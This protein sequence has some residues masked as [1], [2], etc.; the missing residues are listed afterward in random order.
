MRVFSDAEMQRRVRALQ[1]ELATL[2]ADAAVLHT[3]DNSFYVSG[4][5]LLSGWGRPAVTAVTAT[6]AATLVVAMIEKENG[7]RSSWITDVRAYADEENVHVVAARAIG[8][9]LRS[10]NAAR[11]RVG[12]EDEHLSLG[13]RRL[14]QEALPE[15]TFVSI[16]PAMSRLRI[17]KSEEELALLRLGGRIAQVGARAFLDVVREGATELEVTSHAVHEMNRALARERPNSATSTYAYCHS[18]VH[19]LTP[20]LHPTDRRLRSGEVVGLNV[21]PVIWGYCMELERTLVLSEPT[22][23]QRRALDAVNAAFEAGKAALRPGMVTGEIDRLTRRIL[24]EA[25]Y[26]AFIRHGAGHAHGIMI[27]AASREELGELRIYNKEVL[28]RGMVN[29]VEPGVYLPE[30][31]GFR[32]SDVLAVTDSGSELLTEFPRDVRVG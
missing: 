29:S 9:F 7:E 21:F 19:S 1:G 5:A 14:L 6:G 8:D 17:V 10:Q 26:A 16:S 31:G 2:G 23:E 15:A 20:H 25:G 24:E 30:L 28:R 32:H 11:G 4:H 18:G 27:G 22:R 12:V 13:T 3:P